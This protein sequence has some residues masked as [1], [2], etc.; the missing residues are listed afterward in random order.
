[1]TALRHILMSTGLHGMF[2][3]VV[4]LLLFGAQAMQEHRQTI[5]VHL[6]EAVAIPVAVE[7]ATSR[8]HAEVACALNGRNC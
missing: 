2:A 4:A 8:T 6:I 3:V 5:T 7:P 1:M